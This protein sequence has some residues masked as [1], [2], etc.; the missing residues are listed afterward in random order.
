[1]NE[2]TKTEIMQEICDLPEAKKQFIL[3]YAAGVVAR[4]DDSDKDG[5]TEE[6]GHHDAQC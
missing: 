5:K 3:G 6:D 4:T 1:M 2:K